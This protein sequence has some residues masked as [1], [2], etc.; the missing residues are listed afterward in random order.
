MRSNLYHLTNTVF[1][2][3]IVSYFGKNTRH[4]HLLALAKL[5]NLAKN[6]IRFIRFQFCCILAQIPDIYASFCKVEQPRKNVVVRYRHLR[7]FM[8]PFCKVEQPRKNA[9][10]LRKVSEES[11]T[12]AFKVEQPC[13]NVMRSEKL[14]WFQ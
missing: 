1:K 7:I 4:T 6:V 8:L 9:L 10:R 11:Q 2:V 12:F 13:K 3:S 5:N 14:N